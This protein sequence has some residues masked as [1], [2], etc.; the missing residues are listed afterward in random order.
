MNDL[1]YEYKEWDNIVR[2]V[3]R[4]KSHERVRHVRDRSPSTYHKRKRSSSRSRSFTR[5]IS[6][7]VSRSESSESADTRKSVNHIDV[8]PD[9]LDD[10][11]LKREKIAVNFFKCLSKSMPFHVLPDMLEDLF[12]YYGSNNYDWK[13]RLE[14]DFLNLT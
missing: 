11:L 13:K 3:S 10:A 12:F 8:L 14:H 4:Y 7:S 6:R 9:M 2:F 1:V 5:S